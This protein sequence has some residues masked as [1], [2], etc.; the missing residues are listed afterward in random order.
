VKLDTLILLMWSS[1]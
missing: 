1:T